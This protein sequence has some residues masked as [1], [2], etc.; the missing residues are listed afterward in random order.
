MFDRLLL[1]VCLLTG[2]R[3]SSSLPCAP[4]SGWVWVWLYRLPTMAVQ[5]HVV[6]SPPEFKHQMSCVLAL[7]GSSWDFVVCSSFRVSLSKQSILLNLKQCESCGKK[8]K[9]KQQDK[10]NSHWI[11]GLLWFFCPREYKNQKNF[12]PKKSGVSWVKCESWEVWHKH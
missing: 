10:W 2:A 12:K 4:N 1:A 3:P 7:N 8:K 11:N 5:W 9:I 6:V